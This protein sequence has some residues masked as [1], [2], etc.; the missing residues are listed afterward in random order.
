MLHFVLDAEDKA[1]N[2]RS[3]LW[4][5]CSRRGDLSKIRQIK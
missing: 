4:K 3:T 2:K 5:L 1:V